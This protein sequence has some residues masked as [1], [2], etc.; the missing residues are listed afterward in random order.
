MKP[1]YLQS[2][3]YCSY[4]TFKKCLTNGNSNIFVFIHMQAL[5]LLIGMLQNFR[6]GEWVQK[7]SK[8]SLPELS[9][10]KIV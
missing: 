7:V 5:K 6:A 4:Y 2:L 10:F 8:V 3:C 1:K 9:T